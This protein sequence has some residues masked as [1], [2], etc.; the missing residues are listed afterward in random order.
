LRFLRP[1]NLPL[2]LF[3]LFQEGEGNKQIFLARFIQVGK[4]L[5]PP[6]ETTGWSSAFPVV[7]EIS[8]V[9]S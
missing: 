2:S 5:E 6:V 1:R 3:Y 7:A 9:V 4:K 8:S